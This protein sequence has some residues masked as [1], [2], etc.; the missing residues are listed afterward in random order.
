[1]FLDHDAKKNFDVGHL[2]WRPVGH[3][4]FF[5]EVKGCTLTEES[6]KEETVELQPENNEQLETTDVAETADNTVAVPS[7]DARNDEEI[8]DELPLDAVGTNQQQATEAA[9]RGCVRFVDFFCS[10]LPLFETH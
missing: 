5:G 2:P 7:E 8:D 9:A 1:M 4:D 10:N 6:H 3:S